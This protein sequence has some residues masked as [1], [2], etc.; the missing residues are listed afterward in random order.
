MTSKAQKR[1]GYPLPPDEWEENT[2]SF[3]VTIPAGEE[4]EM[5][6]RAQLYELGK[7][8]MWK[9]DEERNRAATDSATNW[10]DKLVIELDCGEPPMSCGDVEDCLE[11][12]DIIAGIDQNITGLQQGGSV[13]GNPTNLTTIIENGANYE[14]GNDPAFTPTTCGNSDKDKLW[15]GINAFVDFM[16]NTN[17]DFFQNIASY[18]NKAALL[19]DVIS[20]IPI[21]GLLPVDEGIDIASKLADTVSIEYNSDVTVTGLYAVKCALF[22][23]AVDADCN[24][25]INDAFTY[26]LANDGLAGFTQADDFETYVSAIIGGLTASG[27]QYFNFMAA[28]QLTIASLGETFVQ[29]YGMKAYT[30][31]AQ[32]GALSPNGSWAVWCDTCAT[33]TG[34]WTVVLDYANDYVATGSEVVYRN[35]YGVW[36]N[37]SGSTT[38]LTNQYA[39]GIIYTNPGSAGTIKQVNISNA[40][41]C[42]DIQANVRKVS[43]TASSVGI[44]FT[45]NSYAGQPRRNFSSGTFAWTTA[46]PLANVGG[47]AGAINWFRID[48]NT[49]LA[50][51]TCVAEIRYLRLT[52]TGAL[53]KIS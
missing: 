51:Q 31:S 9:R 15:G 26:F 11:S 17:I 3:C 12:S 48:L 18:T 21:I 43:G 28:F 42:I 36:T 10:R 53:P 37:V 34:A 47:T 49:T 33:H 19:A 14:T 23:I 5:A 39:K 4:W 30:R 52:G 20:A 40:A 46:V 13:S 35:M 2:Q 25:S 8:W 45:T 50:S 1:K 44:L 27:M 6:F 41:Q 32:A 24:F 29:P 16:H 7:Y 22:C 38:V